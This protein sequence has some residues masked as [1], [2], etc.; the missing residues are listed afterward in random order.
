M[1]LKKSVP[2]LLAGVIVAAGLI[3]AAVIFG[4]ALAERPMA[5]SFSGSLVSAAGGNSGTMDIYELQGYLGLHMDWKPDESAYYNADSEVPVPAQPH[6]DYTAAEAQFTERVRAAIV[7]GAWPDF[8]YI[9]LGGQLRFSRQAV[10]EWVAEK[11]REQLVL[12][13]S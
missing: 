7:S 9:E 2:I 6:D 4:G 13:L 8:P 11:S 1:E 5:G 10:D 12:G 3:V